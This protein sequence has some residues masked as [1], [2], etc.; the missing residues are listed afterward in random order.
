MSYVYGLRRFADDIELM[1]GSRPGL[2]WMLC[3]KYISPL[4]MLSI[5]F[6]SFYEL[7]NEGS[8]YPAWQADTGTTQKMEWPH[9]CIVAAICLIASS[10]IWIPLVAICRL[11]GVRIVEDTDPAWFP[12]NE[13]KD[14]HGIV[15]HE[16][17]EF[18]QAVF[19]FQPDGSEGMC[20]P[21]FIP[22]KELQEEE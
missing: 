7:I 3:W 9:W 6:A 10:I 4:A 19:F 11:F 5:L 2:Y 22:E 13:L 1:T 17:T 21:L 20:C 15:P 14:V 12:T 18:E 16:P 8:S